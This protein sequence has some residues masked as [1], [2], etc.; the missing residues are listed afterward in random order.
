MVA[1]TMAYSMSGWSEAASKSRLK[2]S[3]FTQSRKRLKTLFQAPNSAGRSRQG[4]PLRAIQSTA[5]TKRRLSPPLRPGP[6]SFPRQCGSI[7]AHWASVSTYRSI[8]S[9]MGWTAPDPEDEVEGQSGQ[10][11]EIRFL[12]GEVAPGQYG[13]WWR[14]GADWRRCRA[15][16]GTGHSNRRGC[17]RLDRG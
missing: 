5:S 1:S 14:A 9:L 6:D 17:G 11:L 10:R 2:T 7:L 4:L 12:F 8:P 3:A 16:V 13:P 15:S